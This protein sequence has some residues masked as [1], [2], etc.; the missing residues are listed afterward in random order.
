M[1]GPDRHWLRVQQQA[2]S[3]EWASVMVAN[4]VVQQTEPGMP[5]AALP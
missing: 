1:V 5:G 4:L 3:R 2:N